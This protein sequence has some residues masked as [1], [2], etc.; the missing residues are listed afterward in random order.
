VTINVFQGDDL[1]EALE[2]VHPYRQYTAQ[3]LD[4]L[5][6]LTGYSVEALYGEMD[7]SV[8]VTSEDAYRLIVAL[9]KQ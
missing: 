7:L 8:G 2:E 1:V 5:A 4:L 6:R 9:R 3:E